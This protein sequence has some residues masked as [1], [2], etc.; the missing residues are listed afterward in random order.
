MKTL[1]NLPLTSVA[2]AGDQAN[3]RATARQGPVLWKHGKEPAA[4][5]HHGLRRWVSS[6]TRHLGNREGFLHTR[7]PVALQ[8]ACEFGGLCVDIRR[9]GG[10]QCGETVFMTTKHARDGRKNRQTFEK[11]FSI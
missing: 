7:L 2:A 10:D 4:P 8:F 6:A 1:S 11:T 5:A 9:S 3:Q